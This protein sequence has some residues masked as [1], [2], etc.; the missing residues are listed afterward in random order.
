MIAQIPPSE[1][2]LVGIMLYYAS[3]HVISQCVVDNFFKGYFIGCNLSDISKFIFFKKM[4]LK[5]C[6]TINVTQSAT[7]GIFFH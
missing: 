5:L 3:Q 2:S 7:F 6:S 4:F 1:I